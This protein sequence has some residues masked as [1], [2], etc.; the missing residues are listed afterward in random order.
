MDGC[1]QDHYTG[2]AGKHN[3]GGP[4]KWQLNDP[5]SY[6]AFL[7]QITKALVIYNYSY[8]PMRPGIHR[9]I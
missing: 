1:G 4:R 8:T 7:E 2:R 6:L 5:R 9:E 3:A